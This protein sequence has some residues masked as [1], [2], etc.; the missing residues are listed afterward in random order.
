MIDVHLFIPTRLQHFAYKYLY[1]DILKQLVCFHFWQFFKQTHLLLL[2][3]FINAEAYF[4]MHKWK[5]NSRLLFRDLLVFMNC[6]CFIFWYS[7]DYVAWSNYSHRV[8][9]VLPPDTLIYSIILW[10]AI[11][12]HVWQ[13]CF[14]C[15]YNATRFVHYTFTFYKSCICTR[16]W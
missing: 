3:I 9:N 11:I 5:R 2:E 8:R 4:W 12:I 10:W 1:I 16:T 14:I 13:P 15:C 7:Y 6:K